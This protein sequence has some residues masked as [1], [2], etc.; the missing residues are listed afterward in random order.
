MAEENE[1]ADQNPYR[2]ATSIDTPNTGPRPG[3]QAKGGNTPRADDPATPKQAA[4]QAAASNKEMR[5]RGFG[6]HKGENFGSDG[7]ADTD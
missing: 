3:G 1:T 6:D 2:E 5:E 7:T 4:E